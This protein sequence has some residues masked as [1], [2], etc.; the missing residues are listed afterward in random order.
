MDV[1]DPEKDEVYI[2]I[3]LTDA[4]YNQLFWGGSWGKMVKDG[5]GNWVLPTN[6]YNL[7]MKLNWYVPV[8]I[9]GMSSAYLVLRDDK[10][11]YMGQIWLE[12]RDGVLWFPTERLDCPGDIVASIYEEETGNYRRWISSLRGCD[13]TKPTEASCSVNTSLEGVNLYTNENVHLSLKEDEDGKGE[14]PLV[15]D[16]ITKEGFYTFSARTSGGQVPKGIWLRCDWFGA[17]EIYYFSGDDDGKVTLHLAP[18]E[19]H[20]IYDWETF[21]DKDSFPI[22]YYDGGKG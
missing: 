20:V 21:D 4:D 7:S 15:I 2:N 10:G 9:D 11:N 3:S 16:E 17:D 19:Y 6:F 14:S 18:G 8:K 13:E 5:S 12:V 1:L 22:Y